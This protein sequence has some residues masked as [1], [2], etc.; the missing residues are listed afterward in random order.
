ML[1]QDPSGDHTDAPDAETDG[2]DSDDD[3]DVLK[4]AQVIIVIF[5]PACCSVREVLHHFMTLTLLESARPA[6]LVF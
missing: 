2:V 4:P 5:L 1:L 3:N 6:V